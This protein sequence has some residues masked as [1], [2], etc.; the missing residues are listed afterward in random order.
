MAR[1][2]SLVHLADGILLSNLA[3]LVARDRGTTA[4][5][6]AHIAEVDTRRLYVPEGF[7]S[8]F[9]Y[10]VHQLRLSEDSAYKRIQAARTAR[11]FPHIFDALADGR[12]HLTAVK[13][14]GPYLTP[15]NATELLEA[16][17]R[18]T[19][20]EVE[21]LLAERFPRSETLAL[22]ETLPPSP[23][24]PHDQRS[25]GPV[26]TCA[27]DGIQAAGTL[28][29]RRVGPVAAP[30]TTVTPEAPER[31]LFQFTVGRDTHD[32]LRYA[33]ALLSHVIRSG[34]VAEVIARALKALIRELEKR[35]FAATSR[36]RSG[37]R[38][39]TAR[40]CIPAHVMRAV[41]ERDG[42]R[43]TFV[44]PAGQRCPARA[45]LQFDHIDPVALGGQATVDRIRLRC[46]AHNQYA[47]EC[48]FGT[49]FM[50]HKREEARRARAE[51]RRAAARR[52]DEARAKAAAAAE[53]AAQHDVV[54]GLRSLG[55]RADEAR[56]GAERCGALPDDTPLEERLRVAL[57]SLGRAPSRR[58][59][60]AADGLG[61]AL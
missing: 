31:F 36:P 4:E 15:G 24:L 37:H 19:T 61:A 5:L 20:R 42:G 29:P 25:P 49:E 53:Q 33:Q 32:D 27:S 34:D 26:E 7:P 51:A 10:C 46:A 18:K 59:C 9:L 6:L 41:W 28:A 56:R 12:L 44:G 40:R 16:A 22:V 3:A 35:K 23:P 50:R 52:A 55:F 8:M 43:C 57:R 45:F 13:L 60:S 2:Y 21:Q 1:S 17:A 58:W 47:A 39:A 11:Q 54:S 38:R 14:L 30:R 48:T